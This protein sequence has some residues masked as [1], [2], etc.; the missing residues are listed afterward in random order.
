MSAFRCIQ[1]GREY[2]EM[3]A[4]CFC[5]NKNPAWWSV[6]PDQ[7][8]GA[9]ASEAQQGGYAAP[10]AWNG[11]PAPQPNNGAPAQ[12]GNNAPAQWG[13]NAPGQWGNNTP[14]PENGPQTRWD[15]PAPVQ[16]GGAPALREDAQ[17]P[18]SAEPKGPGRVEAAGPAPEAA[19]QPQQEKAASKKPKKKKKGKVVAI[20]L[21]ALLVLCAAGAA[22]FF[23]VF[24]GS[25]S[26]IFG[27]SWFKP[28]NG[29]MTE[30]LQ[31][32]TA[33][34]N[35]LF[36]TKSFTFRLEVGGT[37]MDGAAAFGANAMK[38]NFVVHINSYSYSYDERTGEEK[39]EPSDDYIYW[40]EGR[41]YLAY[42]DDDID[43]LDLSALLK[44]GDYAKLIREI[45]DLVSG[46]KYTSEDA[47]KYFADQML[48]QENFK[49]VSKL[50]SG[51]KLNRASAE[52]LLNVLLLYRMPYMCA[53]FCEAFDG[54]YASDVKYPDSSLYY[55]DEYYNEMTYEQREAVSKEYE[56][57]YDAYREGYQKALNDFCAD[58]PALKDRIPDARA[59][60]TLV[61][62]FLSTD[63]A[64]VSFDVS[65][66][67]NGKNGSFKMKVNIPELVCDF[68]DYAFDQEVFKNFCEALGVKPAV[69]EERADLDAL[70]TVLQKRYTQPLVIDYTIQKGRLVDLKITYDGD[71]FLKLTVNDVNSAKFDTEKYSFIESMPGS[72]KVEYDSYSNDIYEWFDEI[73]KQRKEQEEYFSRM[74]ETTAYAYDYDETENYGYA[75]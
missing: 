48:T 46:D 11:A 33:A 75:E 22:V 60:L 15:N 3:P 27:G 52:T 55:T 6:V 39:R 69:V 30:P 28:E 8:A 36:N 13:N 4:S 34:E 5:G 58:Y 50:V 68:L 66:D 73:R 54:T 17:Q 49:S 2:E 24:N 26:A 72:K 9:K 1:C 10:P 35:T 37:E 59:L 74:Q 42:G 63:Q 47:Q 14:A 61:T 32:L 56:D 38:S 12:W 53:E 71:V 21:A 67:G 19:Q 23:F 41:F 40:N 43:G 29:N 65:G 51:G 62:N 20:V 7:S 70:F 25:V 64:M 44:D 18:L 31:L 57:A 16:Q 45:N